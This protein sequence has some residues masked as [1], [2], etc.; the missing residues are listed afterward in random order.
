M[1]IK[2]RCRVAYFGGSVVADTQST[3]SRLER[4]R[5]QVKARP[6]DDS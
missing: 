1:H 4:I 6:G 5:D 2:D 3:S